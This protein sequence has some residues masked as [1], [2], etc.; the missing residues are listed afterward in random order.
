MPVSSA[1]RREGRKAVVARLDARAHQAQRLGDPVHGPPADRLV[2]V[3]RPDAARLPR[4]PARQQPHQRARVAHVRGA[5]PWPRA[6][7]AA[8]RRGS[9]PPVRLLLHRRPERPHRVRASSAC[10]RSRGSCARRPARRPSRRTAPR[11]ARS[12]CRPAACSRPGAGRRGRSGGRAR[13]SAP[14]GK[15]SPP[16][17][18]RARRPACRRRSTGSSRRCACRTR[19]RAPCRR[20]SPPPCRARAPPG[21]RYRGGSAR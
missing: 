17:S 16:I 7:R 4:E 5:R 2:A 14:T 13:H 6:G 12:T 18:S 11:G 21:R 19:A 9:Q 1:P 10:P 20:C 3:E 15:P 8:P